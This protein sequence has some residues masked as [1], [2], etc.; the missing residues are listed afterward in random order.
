MSRPKEPGFG[1]AG[2]VER[3][4]IRMDKKRGAATLTGTKDTL[5]TGV[6]LNDREEKVLSMIT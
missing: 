4:F 6:L 2:L 3:H 1:A 5:H